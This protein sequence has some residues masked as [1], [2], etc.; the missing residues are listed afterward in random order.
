[1]L[2]FVVLHVIVCTRCKNLCSQSRKETVFLVCACTENITGGT[3]FH[4]VMTLM[5][6]GAVLCAPFDAC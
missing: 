6:L 3:E 2:S 1:M 4:F 5:R